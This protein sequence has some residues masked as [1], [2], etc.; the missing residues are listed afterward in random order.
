MCRDIVH[1]DTVCAE[2][3]LAPI[4]GTRYHRWT[5]DKRFA[6]EEDICQRCHSRLIRHG[7][8]LEVAFERP[9]PLL[10]HEKKAVDMRY[11]KIRNTDDNDQPTNH[12]NQTY[13]R[14]VAR[15]MA[16]SVARY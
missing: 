3:Q 14:K 11:D 5:T 9:R 10:P 15:P 13:I 1:E 12:S 4:I 2:C 6:E 16:R 8:Y 7:P